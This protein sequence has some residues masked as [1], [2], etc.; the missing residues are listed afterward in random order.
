MSEYSLLSWGWLK[1]YN[2]KDYNPTDDFYFSIEFD[3][4]PKDHNNGIISFSFVICDLKGLNHFLKSELKFDELVD[5]KGTYVFHRYSYQNLI[6][7]L[8][9]KIINPS[10]LLDNKSFFSYLNENFNL[11]SD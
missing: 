6:D 11:L 5:L 7:F 9:K 8:D 2:L 10:K 1:P 4:G 3:I